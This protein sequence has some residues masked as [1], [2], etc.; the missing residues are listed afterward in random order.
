MV[1]SRVVAMVLLW[2]LA[3]A[4]PGAGGGVAQQPSAPAPAQ[5]AQ[6]APPPAERPFVPVPGTPPQTLPPQKVVEVVVRGN[7]HIP[8]DEVLAV[9]S[10][11]VNDPLSEEKLRNDIQS[12]LNLGFFADA[13]VRIESAPGGV[14]VVFLVVENPVITSVA[15]QGNTVVS[16][17]D[18]LKALGVSAGQVLNTVA[19]RNGARAVERLYQER[20]YVL[21]RVADI[22]VSPESVL[23]V[24]IAEGR[25]EGVT[26]EGLHKTK[27]YVVRRELLFHPGDVFNADV[28]NR[29]LRRLFAL[30]YFSDVKAQPGPG[31]QPDTVDVTVSV[32][33]QKTA[34]VSLGAGYSTVTGIQGLIGL[35]DTDFGGNGQ[36]VTAQYVSTAL[37]GN[38]FSLTFHEPYWE[39]SRTAFDFLAYNSTT[40]PTDYSRGFASAFQYNMYQAGGQVTWTQ[41]LDSIH[42]LTYGVKNST[43]TFGPPTFGTPPPPGFVFTP[44]TVNALLLT[45]SQDTRDD[46]QNPTSGE[47]ITLGTTAAATL[48]G[49]GFSFQK[50]ELDYARYFPLGGDSTIVAHVHLGA[51]S[52]ALP[53]Q[54]QFYLGGQTSL[55]GF[56]SGRFRGDDMLLATAEYHF[57]ISSLPFLQNFRGIT[58]IVFVDAGDA[59][60]IGAGY[61]FTLHSDAGIGIQVRTPIGPF[62]LDYGVS[63]E[64]GQL[65]IS[66]GT[67]F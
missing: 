21:A 66:T 62:R 54:E 59:Q 15:V 38:N 4:G 3:L 55:R 45:L 7:E 36:A 9:V 57:P 63:T 39:G 42:A 48:L 24:T 14:R 11:R 65:W 23:A 32:T 17:A 16:T 53:I 43:T 50:Y 40:I 56:A 41:P 25:I 37:N 1:V 33:E 35:R 10:T 20:G 60:P 26:I 44:G 22:N 12:I 34:A 5:P 28:V 29:S 67:L 49:G 47:R 6:P 27:D 52:T 18:I 61:S 51:G 31:T 8:A 13:V 58:G 19:L 64:G 2:A 46:P 30:Q